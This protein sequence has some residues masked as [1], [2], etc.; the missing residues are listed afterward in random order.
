[1]SLLNSSAMC[2]KDFSDCNQ[3][4]QIHTDVS[5]ILLVLLFLHVYKI[6]YSSY[7]I[8]GLCGISFRLKVSVAC[9]AASI[10]GSICLS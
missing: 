5:P 2:E 3:Q 9:D 7:R 1:V 8:I 4:E 6:D 10:N